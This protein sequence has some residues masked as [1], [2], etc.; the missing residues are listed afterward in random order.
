M[1]NRL[2]KSHNLYI[3]NFLFDWQFL[4]SFSFSLPL[5]ACLVYIVSFLSPLIS[6]RFQDHLTCLSP[7]P[8]PGFSIS[9]TVFFFLIIND[10]DDDDDATAESWW[11]SFLLTSFV[12]ILSFCCRQQMKK[13]TWK[14]FARHANQIRRNFVREK[15][16]IIFLLHPE[17]EVLTLLFNDDNDFERGLRSSRHHQHYHHLRPSSFNSSIV[18][19][20][21]WTRGSFLESFMRFKKSE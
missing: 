12:S 16:E 19:A 21:C 1:S 5:I 14:Q 7:L 15:R 2:N 18:V 6:S 17:K 11:F 8:W 3:L 4:L 13:K 10:D 9:L 20:F